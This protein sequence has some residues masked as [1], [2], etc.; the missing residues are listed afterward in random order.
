VK[1]KSRKPSKTFNPLLARQI[2][3]LAGM[4]GNPVGTPVFK[5]QNLLIYGLSGDHFFMI[6]RKQPDF[7][8]S[9]TIK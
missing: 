3:Q 2:H 6:L 1:P 9:H 4:T 7:F 8:K 5:I